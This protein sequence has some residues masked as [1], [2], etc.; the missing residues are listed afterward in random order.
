[1]LFI[2]HDTEALWR[3]LHTAKGKQGFRHTSRGRDNLTG[4]AASFP[5][6]LEQDV[7]LGNRSRKRLWEQDRSR[8]C[9]YE[10]ALPRTLC[11]L[12]SL[13]LQAR[14]PIVVSVCGGTIFWVNPS[15]SMTINLCSSCNNWLLS[16]KETLFRP[17]FIVQIK[18]SEDHFPISL[19][20]NSSDKLLSTFG[21]Y[22]EKLV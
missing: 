19:C 7:L 4:G 2:T 8:E 5:G 18:E 6:R 17:H 20:F 22:E 9:P 3:R 12:L 14:Q 1:M 21:A 15:P 16:G 10:Q 13:W 11:I